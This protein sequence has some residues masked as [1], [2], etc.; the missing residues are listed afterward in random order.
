MML[1]T[2]CPDERDPLGLGLLSQVPPQAPREDWLVVLKVHTI[3]VFTQLFLLLAFMAFAVFQP[4][5]QL[6]LLWYVRQRRRYASFI[7]RRLLRHVDEAFAEVTRMNVNEHDE[8]QQQLL[9]EGYLEAR[10]R[11]D[12]AIRLFR[13]DAC[14]VLY[15]SQDLLTSSPGELYFVADGEEQEMA[16][17]GYSS[18]DVKVEVSDE[19]LMQLLYPERVQVLA[20]ME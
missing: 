19:F 14:K 10:K 5:S 12:L 16:A 20:P 8:Q 17:A 15:P 11:A 7:F 2:Y 1:F 3:F 6:R 18:A 13:R 9:L 4:C